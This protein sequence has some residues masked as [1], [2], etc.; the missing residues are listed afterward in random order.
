MSSYTKFIKKYSDI[1]EKQIQM[2][3]KLYDKLTDIDSQ[4]TKA[5]KYLVMYDAYIQFASNNP[6]S[7]AT[8]RRNA[9]RHEAYV[10]FINFRDLVDAYN[11]AYSSI[12]K[13]NDSRDDIK[14]E[15][16]DIFIKEFTMDSIHIE[17]AEIKFIMDQ[18]GYRYASERDWTQKLAT[19][20]PLWSNDDFVHASHRI[21]PYPVFSTEHQYHFSSSSSSYFNIDKDR[22]RKMSVGCY[23]YRNMS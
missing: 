16:F 9:V 6:S 10:E 17:P 7:K 13:L 11:D 2:L 20:F 12:I 4:R 21:G 23:L 1:S 5:V 8:R 3:V 22:N 15:L 14:A 19:L 18:F